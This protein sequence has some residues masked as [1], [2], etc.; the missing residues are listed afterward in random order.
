MFSVVRVIIG[1]FDKGDVFG[2]GIVFCL[3][4]FRLIVRSSKISR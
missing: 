4:S 3:K 2:I 1:I